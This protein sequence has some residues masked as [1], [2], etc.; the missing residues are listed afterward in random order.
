MK[1]ENRNA[2]VNAEEYALHLQHQSYQP[3][4]ESINYYLIKLR[5]IYGVNWLGIDGNMCCNVFG[6]LLVMQRTI[7]WHF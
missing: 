5:F 7:L 3:H 1:I 6:L 4:A 2:L